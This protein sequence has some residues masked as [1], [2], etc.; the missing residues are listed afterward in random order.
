MTHRRCNIKKSI[1]NRAIHLYL[2]GVLLL[3]LCYVATS[4]GESVN[5][6]RIPSYPVD[7]NLSTAGQWHTYG[8]GGI[9]DYKIFIKGSQP[10]N[11]PWLSTTYTGFGGVLLVGVDPAAFFADEA[12]PYLP[13]AF[14]L[15]CPVEIDPKITVEVDP[16][17]FE[18]VCPECGSHYTLYSGGGPVSGPA[19]G[20]K[21]GLQQYRCSGTPMTGFRIYR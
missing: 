8:I 16:L 20:Y 1:N 21:Y 9:G 15:A 2:Q 18:A 11:F 17:S 10:S 13:M 5:N 4:C 6:K 3:I 14:D 7:I 12:W 19:V